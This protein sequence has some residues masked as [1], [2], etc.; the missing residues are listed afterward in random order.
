MVGRYFQSL[1]EKRFIGK[2]LR[3]GGKYER[4][5]D[6]MTKLIHK[7]R[8]GEFEKEFNKITTPSAIANICLSCPLPKCDKSVC[9]RF[10]EE[11]RKIKGK[12]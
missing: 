2:P 6:M 8:N 7:Y 11:K 12:C 5:N 9:K 4:K 1:F 3:T 10:N